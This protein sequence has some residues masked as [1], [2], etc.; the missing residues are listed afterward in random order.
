MTQNL[1]SSLHYGDNS[2]F[3]NENSFSKARLLEMY[4]PKAIVSNMSSLK[5]FAFS[6][7]KKFCIFIT[8]NILLLA[9]SEHRTVATH[10]CYI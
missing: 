1:K 2:K 8:G 7:H 10:K 9:F 5:K 6:V 4:Q 3:T